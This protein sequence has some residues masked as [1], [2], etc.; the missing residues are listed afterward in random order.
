MYSQLVDDIR[1]IRDLETVI[2]HYYPNQLKNK[3]MKCPFHNESTPSFKIA[4]K[5]NG[6]FYKCFGCNEGGDIIEFIKKVENVGFIKALEKAYSILN[7]P[8]NLPKSN[9]SPIS[10]VNKENIN[11]Y[12]EEKIKEYLEAHDLDSAFR[13][14]CK[15]DKE[16]EKSYYINFPYT[17]HKN[18]PLKIWENL[19]EIL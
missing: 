3:T 14:E 4:E 10:I 16:V 18:K 9:I 13:Y 12:Y 19:N 1:S 11:Q 8:L 17:D 15:K 2:N 5:N 6:A 7:R